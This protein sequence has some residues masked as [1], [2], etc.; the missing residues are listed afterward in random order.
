MNKYTGVQLLESH[1][2]EISREITK[3]NL[4]RKK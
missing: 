3:I 2:M 4:K 1:S